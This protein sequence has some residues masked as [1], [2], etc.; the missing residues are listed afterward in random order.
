LF[1]LNKAGINLYI[2]PALKEG[3]REHIVNFIDIID[4]YLSDRA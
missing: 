2:K 3:S 1:R 4:D